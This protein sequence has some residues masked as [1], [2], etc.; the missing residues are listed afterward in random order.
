MNYSL[1]V[2]AQPSGSRGSLYSL[3]PTIGAQTTAPSLTLFYLRAGK[4][5]YRLSFV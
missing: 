5:F 2:P 4:S 1:G 3:C